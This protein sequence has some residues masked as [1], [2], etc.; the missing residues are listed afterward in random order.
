MI[1]TNISNINHSILQASSSPSVKNNPYSSSNARP[2]ESPSSITTIS[3]QAQ[4]ANIGS[5]FDVSNM[6]EKEMGLMSK[7]L[8]DSGLI[9]SLEFA[10]MSFPL[11][12]MRE[13][14]GLNTDVSEK[15]DYLH[16]YT[17]G[18]DMA[19]KNNASAQELTTWENIVAIFDKLDK[20]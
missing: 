8:F 11:G 4:L 7:Q 17:V 9:G 18:L 16:Q 15:I 1:N 13:N 10:V 12:E 5:K 19:K 14:M 3:P 6:T 2:A 20:T